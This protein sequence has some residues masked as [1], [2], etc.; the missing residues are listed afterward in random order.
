MGDTIKLYEKVT[1]VDS[2][3][4]TISRNNSSQPVLALYKKVTNIMDF[5]MIFLNLKI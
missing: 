1:N 3:P 2:V 4:I 5:Q